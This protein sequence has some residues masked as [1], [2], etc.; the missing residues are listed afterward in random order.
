[1]FVALA[2][3]QN[4]L[5]VSHCKRKREALVRAFWKTLLMVCGWSLAGGGGT[6]VSDIRV[7]RLTT[8]KLPAWTGV[9]DSATKVLRNDAVVMDDH[10][11]NTLYDPA[12]AAGSVEETNLGS[13]CDIFGFYIY[14]EHV[15]VVAVS[16]ALGSPKAETDGSA[17]R[18]FWN[19]WHF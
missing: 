11:A 17:S 5:L 19:P 15:D 7:L 18:F 6:A 3:Y 2:S 8:A 12:I 1:M 16:L 13:A 4:K 14:F 10:H 9:W